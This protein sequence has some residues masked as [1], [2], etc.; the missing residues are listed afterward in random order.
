[1]PVLR[2]KSSNFKDLLSASEGRNLR[3]LRGRKAG[4][5]GLNENSN[6]KVLWEPD[7]W[8]WNNV[9]DERVMPVLLEWRD[10]RILFMA[11][12]GWAIE[13]AMIESDVD[14]RADVIV[15]GRHLH[16]ASLGI[17]FLDA[18][19]AQVVI[20]S[21]SDFPMEQRIPD[22]WRKSCESR[23]IQVFHQGESGAVTLVQEEGALVLRGFVDGKEIRLGKR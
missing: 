4:G 7:F 14:L 17:P 10:W 23:G 2:A 1:M 12:A 20:A 15:A 5:Y 19:G 11:D 21:H 3:L 9:A 6:L 8:N 13:R 16:D 22:W 18:T